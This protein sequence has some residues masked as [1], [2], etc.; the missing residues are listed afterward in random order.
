MEGLYFFWKKDKNQISAFENCWTPDSPASSQRPQHLGYSEKY[1]QCTLILWEI[2]TVHLGYSGRQFRSIKTLAA[3]WAQ[4]NE[5]AP[6]NKTPS[7]SF[8]ELQSRTYK[9]RKGQL[10]PHVKQSRFFYH[11][12]GQLG[13]WVF[14]AW[15]TNKYRSRFD[16]RSFSYKWLVPRKLEMEIF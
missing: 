2:L 11:Q 6:V 15:G 16:D 13:P 1:S 10:G 9:H 4:A 12:G 5:K 3:G 7:R 8:I 14:P